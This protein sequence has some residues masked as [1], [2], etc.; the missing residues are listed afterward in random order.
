M[1]L[2][3]VLIVWMR[4]SKRFGD[5]YSGVLSSLTASLL[6]LEKVCSYLTAPTGSGKAFR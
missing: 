3:K 1:P 4:V 2:N 5:L 6:G